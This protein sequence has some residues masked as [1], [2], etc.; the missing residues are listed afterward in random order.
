M[1]TGCR[2]RNWNH[3]HSVAEISQ[4]E[5]LALHEFSVRYRALVA[6]RHPMP[7]TG[8]DVVRDAVR[9]QYAQEKEVARGPE[10]ES[11]TPVREPEPMEPE[12]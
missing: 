3:N 6:E 10:I 12:M 5:Q 9:E 8:F 2:E 4:R 11:P 1:K 7:E